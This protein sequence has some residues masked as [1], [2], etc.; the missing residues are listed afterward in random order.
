MQKPVNWEDRVRVASAASRS[1]FGGA[2]A[3]SLLQSEPAPPR[4]VSPPKQSWAERPP[5]QSPAVQR[6]VEASGGAGM[7]RLLYPEAAVPS[8]YALE[9]AAAACGARAAATA[10][11]RRLSAEQVAA[12]HRD[13]FVIVP[14]FTAEEA[15]ALL[16][17]AESDAVVN[18]RAHGRTDAEGFVSKLS[19][20]NSCGVNAYGAVARSARM[21]DNAETLLGGPSHTCASTGEPAECYHYH[22]KVMIKEAGVGGA[23]EWHQ[24]YGYWYNNGCMAPQMLSAMVALNEHTE[25][26]GCLRVLKGSHALGRLTHAL[27]GGQA[28]ADPER[29]EQARL[30]GHEE[31]AVR[32]QPGH[33]LFFHCNLLHAS[34]RN[35]S[36][37]P[38]WSMITAYNARANNPFREHHHPCYAPL[39]RWDDGAVLALKTLGVRDGDGTVFMQSRDDASAARQE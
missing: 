29:V 10:T 13:G 28:G 19:L 20:W 9:D 36:A 18:E 31:V 12:Y 11:R 26:N 22:T 4:A 23:W 34:A 32:L 33:V 1:A 37:G 15:A 16:S 2:G 39:D 21:V 3:K 17:L 24:D 6:R 25:E 35:R 38:R 30:R 8:Q 5:A 27:T 7:R 14:L